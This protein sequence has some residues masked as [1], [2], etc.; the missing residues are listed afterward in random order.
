MPRK[1]SCISAPDG[2]VDVAVVLIV[3]HNAHSHALF[4]PLFVPWGSLFE[5]LIPISMSI[6]I[7]H[8]DWSEWA[9]TS[10][11]RALHVQISAVSLESNRVR[12]T[13]Q[14]FDQR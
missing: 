6:L 11:E 9:E 8:R 3:L 7:N 2:A 12:R 10:N 5:P 1:C 14:E 13:R 4:V